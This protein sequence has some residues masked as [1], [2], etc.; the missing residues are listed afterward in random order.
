M[1]SKSLARKSTQVLA[2]G[3]LW[4]MST[5]YIEIVELGKTLTDYRMVKRLGQMGVRIQT[6]AIDTMGMYLKT[7]HA[8]LVT[9]SS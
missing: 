3:Q 6:S 8:R 1:K 9:K 4:K 5:A 7:N 2:K